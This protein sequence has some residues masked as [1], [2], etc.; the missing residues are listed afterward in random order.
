MK[1]LLTFLISALLLGNSHTY[2]HSSYTMLQQMAR[3][4]GCVLDLNVFTR[5]GYCF[6]QH[7]DSPYA[8]ELVRRGGYDIVFLQDRS[9]YQALIGSA[10][11][12][13]LG[14]SRSTLRLIDS[15]RRYSPDA[16]IILEAEWAHRDG[17]MHMYGVYDPACSTYDSM[18][19][20]I[21]R[22]ESSLASAA[23]VSSASLSAASPAA[24]SLS[25][26]AAPASLAPALRGSVTT[27]PI[28]AAFRLVRTDCPARYALTYKAANA[29]P[30]SSASPSAARDIELWEPDRNHATYAG[31]Y[32]K[33]CVNYLVITGRHFGSGSQASHSGSQSSLSNSQSSLSNSQASHSGS[34]NVAA[35]SSSSYSPFI[36]EL[37]PDTAAYLRG[38]AEKVVFGD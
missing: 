4:E 11:D 14:I 18:Q 34:H 7:L 6:S 12:D 29:R 26:T 16:R 3:T 15:V 31:M 30:A 17:M 8:M 22:G 24:A 19:S 37:D 38:I 13:S 36:G 25:S 1:L 33:C 23:N 20:A 21:L 9:I 32:L 35:H 10:V 27:S 28:G 5:G 2:F